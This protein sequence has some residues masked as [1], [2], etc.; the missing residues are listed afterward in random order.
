MRSR[1]AWFSL[2][3]LL[4]PVACAEGMSVSEEETPEAAA[5]SSGSASG[6]AAGTAGAVSA[7]K[8]GA[9]AAGAAGTAGAKAGSAGAAGAKAGAG[10]TSGGG[11]GAPAGAAGAAGSPKG[12]SGGAAAGSGG[13]AGTSGGAGAP[14][15]AGGAAAGSAGASGASAGMGGASGSGGVAGSGGAGQGGG[16][17]VAG[18]AGGGAGGS[19]GG[20]A[21]SGGAAPVE[22]DGCPGIPLT[23]GDT[24]TTAKGDAK[25]AANDFAPPCGSG[26]G[27]DLVYAITATIDGFLSVSVDGATGVDPVL[28][29]QA[30]CGTGPA[31][32]CKDKSFGGGVESIGT[33][34]AKGSTTYVTVDFYSALTSGAFDLTAKV[35]PLP[36]GSSCP[37]EP[38]AV[39]AG[40]PVTFSGTTVN[41]GPDLTGTGNCAN[42]AAD[43]VL[44]VTPDKTG[45][46]HIEV[47]PGTG[48][49]AM[50][51]AAK[52][53][54]GAQIGCAES[55]TSGGVEKLDVDVVAGEALYVVVDGY[56]ASTGAFA[57][58]MTLTPEPSNDRCATA[59]VLDVVAGTPKIVTGTTKAAHDDAR[60]ETCGGTTGADVFYSITPATNGN[61]SLKLQPAT[62]FDTVL[63]V[64]GGSCGTPGTELGCKD[65]S[66]STAEQIS[67]PVTAGTTYWV[68]VD[69]YSTTATGDFTL[70]ASLIAAPT[71]DTCATAAPVAL[72]PG[73]KL[74][75]GTTTAA[76]A[77]Y[78]ATCGNSA[79]S[80]DVVY[81]VTPSATGKLNVTLDP[82]GSFDSVLTA[83][84]T[85]CADAAHLLA[86]K[87]SVGSSPEAISIDVTAGQTYW[88]VVDGYNG[89]DGDFQLTFDLAA[90]PA[91]DKCAS[92]TPVAVAA[93]APVTLT[94]DTTNAI[95][96]DAGTCGGGSAPDVAYLVTPAATG[97]LKVTLKATSSG[98][99]P[100]L[101]LG[102]GVCGTGASLACKDAT[103]SGGTETTTVAVTGG[104]PVWVIA[105]GYQTSKGAFSITFEQP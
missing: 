93:G 87:D 25:P 57:A 18:A 103:S 16:A 88:I 21:G 60:G 99:D 84:D 81:A 77:D 78:A 75:S 12:G 9:P 69:G 100:L 95:D 13:G 104:Q 4:L 45:S 32:D 19:S 27:K 71:N 97:N 46:L 79:T 22:G 73:Q 61:L 17:G 30:A 59:E 102:T 24:A 28:Y 41:A 53:C 90:A 15:G 23:V 44:A 80:E 105:D 86:C 2:V 43:V 94:G 52:T 50:V 55:A 54:G 65:A 96:D 101:Y 20:A 74:V 58:T 40:K 67:L 47:D 48:F 72:D 83:Y 8:S 26:D 85:A 36:P 5:G 10:G 31:L 68:G 3:S 66:G 63:Y 38:I 56:Q 51:Y 14:A 39:E 89:S 64:T 37:G 91:N 1:L 7:G 6:G 98:F 62:G 82:S 42:T 70:T 49:D 33:Y 34:V 29:A 11:A 92:A 35:S 76:K